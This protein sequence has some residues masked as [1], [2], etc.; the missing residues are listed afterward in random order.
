MKQKEAFEILKLGENIFLTGPAGCGKTF[1]LNQYINH[2]KKNK[3]KTG[4]TASTGIAATHINGRTIHS[5]CGIGISE[6]MPAPQFKNL[7]KKEVL[8]NR[9]I[10]TKVLVIDE[11]SML[12]AKR[13]D[14]IDHICKAIKQDLRPF[15]GMQVILC[16]DFFQLPP[17]ARGSEDGRFVTESNIWQSMDIKICYLQDQYRQADKNFL[18]VLN[19]IRQNSVTKDTSKLLATRLNKPTKVKIKPTK[20]H[21]HNIDV[22]SYNDFELNKLS[23]IQKVYEMQSTGEKKLV[24]SL[25][26][27]CIAPETLKLKVDAVVM[28]VKNNFKKQYVNGTLGKVTNFDKDSG[29]PVIETIS[30]H[31]IIAAPERWVIEE[32]DKDVASISQVP[33]RLAWAITVH[34]SQGMSLD[35][36]EID[37]SKTFEYGM[38]YVALSRVRSLD[39]IT[40]TGIN[41][42]ALQVNQEALKLDKTLFTKSKKDLEKSIKI[43]KKELKKLQKDFLTQSKADSD[44]NLFGIQFK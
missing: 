20:L 43:D 29:Y 31:K 28:F 1:L 4:I 18:K 21:T 22:D 33:L 3:I 7:L 39:G 19:D 16:G 30:G 40:L 13:L 12:N 26:K 2:L 42:L 14:L 44:S 38:G 34:K 6:T 41:K 10:S 17:V 9:I 37:L 27:S 5:W 35:C 8:R 23:G 11:I 36:A 32:G 25:K 24:K 15:G